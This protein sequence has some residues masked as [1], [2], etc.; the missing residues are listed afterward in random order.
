MA[1][2]LAPGRPVRRR[3]LFGALDADGWAWAFVKAFAWFL[4]I[5]LAL[6]YIPDRAYYFTVS[7]TLELGILAWSPV[8]LCPAEN[9]GLECPPPT[10]A[11]VPWELSPTELEL[12]APRTGGAAIQIGTDLLYAGGSDGAAAVATTYRAT[13]SNGSFGRWSE[14]P[15]LPEARSDAAQATLSGVAYLAGGRDAD[16]QPTTSL[17]SI[18]PNPDSGDLG[19]WT[20]VDGVTLP[21]PRA[22]AAAVAV[23]DGIIVIG[24]Y[25]ASGAPTTTVWKATLNDEGALDPFEAQPDL[26]FPVADAG[27]AF[28]GGFIW[29]YGG[30]DANGA[31]G[32]VQ[33]GS[34]GADDAAAG[35]GGHAAATPTPAADQ[36][37]SITRW[38]VFDPANLPAARTNGAAFATNGIL[39]LAGGSD[40]SD[41]RSEL[42]WAVPD[43]L[44]DVPAGWRHVDVTDLPAGGLVGAAPVVISG[45][46]VLI[47]GTT[48]SG[49]IASSVRAD[50]APE[51]PF[52]Q[53][54]PFG[55][56]VP[57]LQIPGEIGQQLGY[58]AAAGLGTGNFL[59]LVIIG[60]M[61][62]HRERVRGW[63]Q[64]FRSRGGRRATT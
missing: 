33:R 53:L 13:I 15:A 22:G 7:R 51:L 56:V 36:V 25:D 27:A 5:I 6:G 32:G 63:W 28:E 4:I 54:G 20:P 43:A 41:P 44:G 46:V 37:E 50:L 18:G 31:S 42:Y 62:N 26:R 16:G 40:G 11:I 17:W 38:A 35:D 21:A 23:A 2:A 12:P 47:G 30:T 19:A 10:G 24:G 52:F 9:R 64:R 1:K 14:G 57:G 39:Y 49:V 60:W 29:V 61:I 48:D 8:N 34:Y 45:H 55:V 59:I 3:A 58:L